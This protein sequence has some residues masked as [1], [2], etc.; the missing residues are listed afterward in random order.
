MEVL[1]SMFNVP[2]FDQL[3]NIW[4]NLVILL[5]SKYLTPDFKSNMSKDTL[6]YK[7]QEKVCEEDCDNVVKN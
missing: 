1:A 6:E 3:I 4:K 7:P 2:D 5:S